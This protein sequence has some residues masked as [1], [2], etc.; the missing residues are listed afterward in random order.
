MNGSLGEL[1]KLRE[2]KL[3]GKCFHSFF[4]S[5]QTFMSFSNVLNLIETQR[6]CAL[7]FLENSPKKIMKNMTRA[8]FEF[9]Y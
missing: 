8:T 5:S 9:F 1:V 2:H 6:K 4:K 7:S 3:T